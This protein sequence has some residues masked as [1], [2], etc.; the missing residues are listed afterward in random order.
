M[1]MTV[2]ESGIKLRA[3]KIISLLCTKNAIGCKDFDSLMELN[4]VVLVGHTCV[5]DFFFL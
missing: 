2:L 3:E 5:K 4:W 1:G